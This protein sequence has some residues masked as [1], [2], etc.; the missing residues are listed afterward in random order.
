MKCALNRD[1]C[2][3]FEEEKEA[4]RGAGESEEKSCITWLAEPSEWW[5]SPSR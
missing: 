2:A 4:E 3:R 5:R 1:G